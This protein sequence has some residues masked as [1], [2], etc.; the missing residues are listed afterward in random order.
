[1]ADQKY[2]V[3]KS[4]DAETKYG[5]YIVYNTKAN[6]KHPTD[7]PNIFS[8]YLDSRSVEGGFYYSGVV[9][10][11]P[12]PVE[13]VSNKPHSHDYIEY[14]IL[15]GT[16][17]DDP[18]DLGGEV[19]FWI[20]DE[21]H[22]ITHTCVITVPAG[23]FHCPFIFTRVDRPILFGSVSPAPILYEH[24]NRDPKWSHLSDPPKIDEVLD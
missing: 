8:M 15:Y 11:K 19:E 18:F 9:M 1:M 7:D 14:I 20:G 5:K 16:N 17:P 21:K 13:A 3:I 24:T 6:P 4:G 12:T 10:H 23:V 22:V 2:G